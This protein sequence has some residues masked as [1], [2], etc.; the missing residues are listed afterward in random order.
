[1]KRDAAMTERLRGV[2]SKLESQTKSG[3]VHWEKQAGSAHRYT[4]VKNN[5][6]I[7]GPATPLADSEVPRYLFI[8]PFDSPDHIEV[9]SNDAELGPAILSLAKEVEEVSQH[10]PAV[11]PFAVTDQLLERLESM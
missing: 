11:D 1:M 8:T 4:Q 6:V 2:I 3:A 5:L 10:E 7:L 9:N